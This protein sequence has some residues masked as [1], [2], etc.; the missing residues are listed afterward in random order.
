MSQNTSEPKLRVIQEY[1]PGKQV[2]LA[3]IITGPHRD[4]LA[5]LDLPQ[6]RGGAIGIMTITPGEG[7]IIAADIATKVAQVDIGVL[8][9][10]RGSLSLLGDVASVEAA[11]Q[12]IIAYFGE[13]LHYDSVELTKS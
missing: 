12:G 4:L 7:V 5:K 11:V 10:G 9:L 2:T 13:V 8:D 1:V 3:H 6:E